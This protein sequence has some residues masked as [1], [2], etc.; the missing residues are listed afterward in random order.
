[1]HARTDYGV[2]WEPGSADVVFGG[3]NL[4]TAREISSSFEKT[5]IIIKSKTRLIPS[6]ANMNIRSLR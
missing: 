2:G 4:R 1:M 3:V 6:P 5:P